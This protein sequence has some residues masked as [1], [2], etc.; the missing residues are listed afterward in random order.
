MRCP[1]RISAVNS[2]HKLD[3]TSRLNYS[4]QWTV[5]HCVKV[6]FIGEVHS[7]YLWQLQTDCNQFRPE[8]KSPSAHPQEPYGHAG[9]GFECSSVADHQDIPD[10]ATDHLTDVRRRD[11]DERTVRAREPP[12]RFRPEVRYVD[13]RVSSGSQEV[14]VAYAPPSHTAHT[15]LFAP[16]SYNLPD[17][18]L[19]IS[20]GIR[21][22]SSATTSYSAISSASRRTNTSAGASTQYTPRQT[23][24][25]SSESSSKKGIV[26]HTQRPKRLQARDMLRIE[27]RIHQNPSSH[28]QQVT[29]YQISNA[30]SLCR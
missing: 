13:E 1:I 11:R 18:S 25:S 23:L 9:T 8:E 6:W 26:I 5:E 30:Q 17:S 10:H 27:E 20:P 12:T 2:K 14:P 4:K 21:T 19:P 16:Q 3:R 29:V 28:L 24:H 15:I 7:G 22:Y